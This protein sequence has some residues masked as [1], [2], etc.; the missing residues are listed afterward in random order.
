M[1]QIKIVISLTLLAVIAAFGFSGCAT[2]KAH[3]KESLMSAAGFHTLSPSTAQQQANY[4]SLPPNKIQRLD[5]NGKVTYAFADKKS[6]VVYVGGEN[7]YQR[8]KQLG[9]Q[10]KIANDELEAAQMNQDA[11]MSWGAW[12]PMGGW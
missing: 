7:E 3:N 10:Q 1:K 4:A 6:G 2:E 8:Y 5:Q 12:G 11:A 9:Q